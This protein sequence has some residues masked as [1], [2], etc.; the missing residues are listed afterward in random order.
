MQIVGDE[1][2]LRQ[3]LKTAVEIDEDKPVLA[4]DASARRCAEF[5][6]VAAELDAEEELVSSRL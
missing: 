6:A 2:Q 4:A 1:N 3:Y 5:V